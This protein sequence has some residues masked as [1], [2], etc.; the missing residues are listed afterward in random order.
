[1][2]KTTLILLSFALFTTTAFSQR[3]KKQEKPV[4]TANATDSIVQ[5]STALGIIK[6]KLYNETPI[7]RDNFLKLVREKTLDS[8]LF[9]RV[10]SNFM[11]QG[12]DVTSKNA[13]PEA[14]LGNGDVGYT[15]PAEI[16]PAFFHKKGALAAARQGDNVN[17]LKASSGCQFYIVQGNKF[18]PSDLDAMENR[19][20]MQLKQGLFQQII[21]RP[22]NDALKNRFIANQQ[23]QNQDSL[24]VL[25]KIAEDLTNAEAAKLVPFKYSEEQKKVYSEIGGTPHLDGEYTVFGEVIEGLEVIDKIAA[26]EKGSNDRPKQDLRMF[27]KI[28]H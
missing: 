26:V 11:I 14:M 2:K 28:I 5:I 22:E 15:L 23:N 25:N 21:M 6:V 18:A 3:T 8:T 4:V 16:K 13:T 20:N 7:H 17:P 24:A 1:M 9:H 10:I 19:H 27:C 12:G